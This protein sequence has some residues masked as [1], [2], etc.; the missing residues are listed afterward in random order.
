[1]KLTTTTFA[2]AL[3][4]TITCHAQNDRPGPPRGERPHPPMPL[5]EVLDADKDHKISAEELK[6]APAALK[7][8]DTDGDG[9]LSPEETRPKPPEGGKQGGPPPQDGRQGPPQGGA[10]APPPPAGAP[11]DEDG[12]KDKEKEKHPVPP[13]IAVLD[14]DRDGKIS[15]AEIE[16]A[17]E[18]LAK[19]DKD[20]DG[21]ITQEEL[22]P[23]AGPHKGGDRKGE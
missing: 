7:T 15:A 10:G 20:G 21:E 5:L 6:G 23:P 19:L 17:A 9:S 12:D 1:M 18:S 11:P 8:L 13:I 14:T 2:A 4:A 3:L 22:R 16:K